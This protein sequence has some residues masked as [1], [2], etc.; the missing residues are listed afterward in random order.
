[1]NFGNLESDLVLSSSGF[2]FSDFNIAQVR[3][4]IGCRVVEIDR[5]L[6]QVLWKTPPTAPQTSRTARVG[7][8]NYVGA[9]F[10][11]TFFACLP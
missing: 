2:R 6:P 3:L 10:I 4:L 8:S 9:R 5:L 7:R 11:G 1:M